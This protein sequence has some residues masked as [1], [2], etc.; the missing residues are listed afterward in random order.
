MATIGTDPAART[1][2]LGRVPLFL[3]RAV[4]SR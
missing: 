3:S 2:A 4:G 1:D